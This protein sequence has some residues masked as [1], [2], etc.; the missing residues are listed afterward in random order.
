MKC[1]RK[2]GADAREANQYATGEDFDRI[3]AE[4]M[5]RLHVIVRTGKRR[6]G[7][8]A[9][10]NDPMLR[11]GLLLLQRPFQTI[12]AAGLP[13]RGNAMRQP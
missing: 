7:Q 11:G 3:F 9:R 13:N 6:I 5:D 1:L 8:N 10:R 4:D 12:K 2:N